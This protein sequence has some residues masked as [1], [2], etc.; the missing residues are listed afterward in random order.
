MKRFAI[1]ICAILGL[2]N[3]R[4]ADAQIELCN[5]SSY[6]LQAAIAIGAAQIDD[7]QVRGWYMLEAKECK[8]VYRDAPTSDWDVQARSV[9]NQHEWRPEQARRHYWCVR[10]GAFQVTYGELSAMPH[11][12]D[13][14]GQIRGCPDGWDTR[15]FQ[16]GVSNDDDPSVRQLLSSGGFYV[17]D[18]SGNRL[19]LA[20]GPKASHRLV[21]LDSDF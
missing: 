4:T 1:L 13:V 15:R 19:P 2:A 6:K 18:A 20:S 3:S 9:D 17:P 21:F 16:Q 14:N 8:V 5:G 12:P 7:V 10:A 11:T